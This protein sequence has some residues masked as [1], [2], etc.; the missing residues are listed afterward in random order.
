L[1][2]AISTRMS[3]LPN[4]AICFLV[5][6]LGH[7]TP[8]IVGSSQAQFEIVYFFGQLIA[9]IFPN[10]DSFNIQAAIST[11]AKVPAEYLA[12]SML[13]CSLYTAIALA[14]ALFLFEDRDLT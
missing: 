4:F 1:S 6:V 5:Y 8:L 12:M 9:V 7:L 3:M 11:G 13:Y 14:V 10:L 2:V